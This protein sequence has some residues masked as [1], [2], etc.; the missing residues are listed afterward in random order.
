MPAASAPRPAGDT[1]AL[2]RW[3]LT[4]EWSVREEAAVLDTAAGSIAYR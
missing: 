3:A 1:F 2:N 4:G